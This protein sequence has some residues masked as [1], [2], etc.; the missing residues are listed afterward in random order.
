MIQRQAVKYYTTTNIFFQSL[1]ILCSAFSIG[2]HNYLKFKF[3]L[4]ISIH[5]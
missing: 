5:V 4:I 3:F 2:I 1:V